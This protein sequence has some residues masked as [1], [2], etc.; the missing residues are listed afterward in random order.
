[1]ATL[2]NLPA[3]VRKQFKL[4]QETGDLTFYATRVS[5]LQCEGLPA[6]IIKLAVLLLR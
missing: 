3:L 2:R 1:M 6:R 4:A 5:I